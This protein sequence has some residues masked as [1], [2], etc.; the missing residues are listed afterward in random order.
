MTET[1]SRSEA[2]LKLYQTINSP[3][4][5]GKTWVKYERKTIDAALD[6]LQQLLVLEG[7]EVRKNENLSN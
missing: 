3:V 1:V 5:A 7:Y 4:S 2:T 6:V